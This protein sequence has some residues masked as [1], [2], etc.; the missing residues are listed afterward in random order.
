MS[1]NLDPLEGHACLLDFHIAAAGILR[2]VPVQVQLLYAQRQRARLEGL[3]LPRG[4]VEFEGHQVVDNA[5]FQSSFLLLM[6]VHGTTSPD[7]SADGVIVR[8]CGASFSRERPRPDAFL[9]PP[10]R[11]TA[12][13]TAP[14]RR[15]SS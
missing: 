12:A 10:P 13:A 15:C 1:Q 11:C 7:E 9:N 4:I 8:T 2:R 3:Q 6:A 5:V 14:S